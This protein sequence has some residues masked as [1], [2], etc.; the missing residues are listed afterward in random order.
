MTKTKVPKPQLKQN[1][2][3]RRSNTKIRVSG[4]PQ[5]TDSSNPAS[6]SLGSV[7]NDRFLAGLLA[8]P[9]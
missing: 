9:S 8:F 7:Q 6:M 3:A 4:E 5:Q 1:R 2:S